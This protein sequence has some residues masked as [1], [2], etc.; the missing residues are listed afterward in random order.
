MEWKVFAS[1]R[2]FPLRSTKSEFAHRKSAPNSGQV[3]SAK[4]QST[5]KCW[6]G[7]GWRVCVPYVCTELPLAAKRDGP[8]I[9]VHVSSPVAGSTLTSAPVSITKHYFE[10]LSLRNNGPSVWLATE[11]TND[12]WPSCFSTSNCMVVGTVSQLPQTCGGRNKRSW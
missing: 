4:G 1:T 5:D 6:K 9:L 10:M 11:V 2:C 12:D 8:G 3:T 7:G